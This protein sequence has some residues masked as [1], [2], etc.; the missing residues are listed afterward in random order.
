[1]TA[2]A[3]GKVGAEVVDQLFLN[4]FKTFKGEDGDFKYRIRIRQM[5][6]PAPAPEGAPFG[7]KYV[8]VKS[9]TLFIDFSDLLVWDDVE[10]G[11]KLANLLV[12]RPDEAL[13]AAR[14]ALIELAKVEAPELVEKA[15]DDLAVGVRGL[16]IRV[17]LRS[18]ERRH[19]GK[20]ISFEGMVVKSTKHYV[21]VKK[22]AWVCK[23]CGET[24]YT[25]SMGDKL[26]RPEHC[27]SCGKTAFEE[28]EAR[29]KLVDWRRVTVQEPP[30]EVPPGQVPVTAEVELVN[31]LVRLA[32]PGDKVVVT[33]IVRA[34]KRSQKDAKIALAVEATGLDV[35]AKE[36]PIQITPEDERRIK[37]LAARPDVEELILN[38]FAPS[39]HGLEPV[40]RA[41]VL[42]LFGGVPKVF[43]DGVRVRGDIHL[44]LV[45]DPGTAKSQLLKYA[46]SLAPRGVY[47]TGKGS[48][49]AGLTATVVKD[50]ES[51]TYALEVGALVLADLGLC[52]VDEIDKMDSKDRVAMHEAME[53]QTV[54]VAKAGIVA[55]LN[56]RTA[57]LAAANPLFGRY[58]PNRPISENISLP[59]TILS[60]FD[61]IFLV[62]DV[63]NREADAELAAHIRAYHSGAGAV[64]PPP[65]DPTLLRKYIAYARANC[66][67]R[68]T[69]AAGRK[70]E[71]FYVDL[72]SK[73]ARPDS[74]VPIT[75]RQLE[76]LIRLAEA[77]AK[78]RLSDTV[79]ERDADAA[80]DLMMQF[81]RSAGIDVETGEIDID[82]V[83]TGKPKSQ[84]ERMALLWD[85]LKRAL[86][87]NG[88]A[89]V[90]RSDF[91]AM[92]VERGFDEDFV[93]KALAAW[94]DQGRIIEPKHGY[95]RPIF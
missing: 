18:I 46:A 54:S 72:R 12:D 66:R 62:R 45:G 11:Y 50:P 4:F 85:M 91:V 87:E 88:G 89:D 39:V 95:I 22:A 59:P 29:H 6:V 60:R 17:P 78:M 81:L 47:T 7:F 77:H 74:P 86:K 73:A 79:E 43:P 1:M 28:D 3:G 38:S 25:E 63:P 67:P 53:Q 68:L 55:T 93:E 41:L 36:T 44:L 21:Y 71:Q 52:A 16:P 33:G 24:V 94:Y 10:N 13:G 19:I 65:V 51:G 9:T 75:P 57:V 61:L 84:R 31:D 83:M 92:A 32:N 26:V 70:L 76:A 58:D 14:L 40:K 30:E 48:T 69:E 20:L 49:A 27:P 37:E 42:Q 2:Q 35:V 90:K 8:E 80:I 23:S 34:V 56:A 64:T 82:T 15:K 5:A